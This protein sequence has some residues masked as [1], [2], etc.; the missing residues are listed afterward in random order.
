MTYL[1]EIIHFLGRS[2]GFPQ[3]D[4]KLHHKKQKS[5]PILLEESNKM[6]PKTPLQD[7]NYSLEDCIKAYEEEP[8]ENWDDYAGG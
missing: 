7:L 8:C 6:S 5:N 3:K 4:S 2:I 1:Q